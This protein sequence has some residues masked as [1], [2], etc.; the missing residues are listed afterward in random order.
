[1]AQWTDLGLAMP[2]RQS[3]SDGW[4]EQFPDLEPFLAGAEYARPWQFRPGFS[5]VMNAFNSGLQQAFTGVYTT[6]QVL[7]DTQEAGTEVLGNQ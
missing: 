1:M 2:T 5:D 4:L 6:D 7:S 3:L